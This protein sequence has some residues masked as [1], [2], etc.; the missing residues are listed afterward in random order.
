MREEE[1]G[2]PRLTE[3]LTGLCQAQV[4]LILTHRHAP[5]LAVSIVPLLYAR[6]EA[7]SRKNYEGV[8][9]ESFQLSAQ[10]RSRVALRAR[11]D[12]WRVAPSTRTHPPHTEPQVIEEFVVLGVGGWSQS[13][14]GE[15]AE[16]SLGEELRQHPSILKD[17]RAMFDSCANMSGA[18]ERLVGDEGQFTV[19]GVRYMVVR[20]TWNSFCMVSKFRRE[21]LVVCS[22][23]AGMLL[24]CAFRRPALAQKVVPAVE[25]VCSLL[26]R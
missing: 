10:W 24:V 15:A 2:G 18:S 21:G 20:R 13:G 19:K 23:P 26:W 22:L 14:G 25:G 1:G 4:L 6:C 8:G 17:F 11:A 3:A 5:L 7:G 16:R 12:A 9:R